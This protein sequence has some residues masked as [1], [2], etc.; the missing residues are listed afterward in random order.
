MSPTG[1][2]IQTLL[3]TSN[4]ILSKVGTARHAAMAVLVTVDGHPDFLSVF[5]ASQ[6]AF[7]VHRFHE[8]LPGCL[9]P[10]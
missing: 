10:F 1:D 9:G 7:A 6:I 3:L 4:R 8:I 5:G 2:R